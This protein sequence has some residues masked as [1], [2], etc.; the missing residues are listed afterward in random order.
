VSDI[1]RLRPLLNDL[2]IAINDSLSDSISI[3][4]AVEK[5]RAAGF[6]VF[7]VLEATIAFQKREDA[8]PEPAE[9]REVHPK[10]QSGNVVPGTFNGYDEKLL[11]E[12]KIRLR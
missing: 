2:G 1:E 12:L 6:D 10:V 4:S 3:V 8:P 5:I 9:P 7:L 11:R